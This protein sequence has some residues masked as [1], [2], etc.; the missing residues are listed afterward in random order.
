MDSFQKFEMVELRSENCWTH[1]RWTRLHTCHTNFHPIE[2][3]GKLRTNFGK[4]SIF[5]GIFGGKYSLLPFS[6]HH[7]ST[8]QVPPV[9]WQLDFAQEWLPKNMGTPNNNA[10]CSLTTASLGRPTGTGKWCTLNGTGA[11]LGDAGR[12]FDD[13]DGCG[14]DPSNQISQL[15][16]RVNKT[17]E[18]RNI[19]MTSRENPMPS[20]YG[21]SYLPNQIW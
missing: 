20:M 16:G 8:W 1:N 14:K 19:L 7:F 13:F 6:S 4:T 11:R 10:R 3:L 15:C 12:R 21:I 18:K 9:W 5:E 17:W 2:F